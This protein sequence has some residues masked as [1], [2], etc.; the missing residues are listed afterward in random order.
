[1]KVF[2]IVLVLVFSLQSWTKADDIRDFQIEGMSIGDSAL[3]Y[4]SKKKITNNLTK[5]YKDNEFIEAEI[6]VD[7]DKYD[8]V[9][10][11]FKKT[12]N[13]YKIVS[14]GG[15]KWTIDNIDLC[16]KIQNEIYNEVF[17][18]F[19]N[20]KKNNYKKKHSGDPSGKST[21]V[22]K[23]LKFKNGDVVTIQCY[24]WSKKMKYWDHLRV[25]ISSKVFEDWLRYK[26]YN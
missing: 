3:N 11:R 17:N 1:M 24:D 21:N 2:I 15:L 5:N 23:G 9:Q 8:V 13:K 12:D 16:Y 20:A 19:K 18:I 7:S 6:E 25:S 26:A 14:M 22:T 10:I 4:F